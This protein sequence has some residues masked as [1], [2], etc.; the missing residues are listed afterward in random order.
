MFVLPPLTRCGPSPY[1]CLGRRH[2]PMCHHQ[3]YQWYGTGACT[4]H[5]W[6]CSRRAW[7][8]LFDGAV[9]LLPD[10][11]WCFCFPGSIRNWET[12]SGVQSRH[13]SKR[14]VQEFKRRK[15][16]RAMR[17]GTYLVQDLSWNYEFLWAKFAPLHVRPFW[18]V[19]FLKNKKE[20]TKSKLKNPLY[21]VDWHQRKHC[22][23]VSKEQ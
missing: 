3:C 14:N 22:R 8:L 16:S 15:I 4:S 21:R 20:H 7:V 10:W 18:H 13:L 19:N 9:P 12:M 6:K 17:V 2:C 1:I 11:P 5:S 23:Q